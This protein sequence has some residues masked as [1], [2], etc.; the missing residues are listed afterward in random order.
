MK[1]VIYALCDPLTKDIRYVG[2]AK[3]RIWALKRMV[4]QLLKEGHV[5]ES[6]KE[7]LRYAARKRPDLFGE[8]A[9]L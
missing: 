3:A 1:V 7:K 5:S 2:K 9:S 4:G 6:N 8:Y